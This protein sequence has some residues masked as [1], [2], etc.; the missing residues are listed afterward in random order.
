M[1]PLVQVWRAALHRPG[2]G[3]AT[4][5]DTAGAVRILGVAI[6]NR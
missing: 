2:E 3:E 6:A 4:A 5:I 1:G